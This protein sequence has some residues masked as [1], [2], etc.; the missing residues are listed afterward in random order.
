VVSIFEPPPPR[1]RFSGM[2]IY[3]RGRCQKWA[4]VASPQG[5]D[6]SPTYL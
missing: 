1:L 4:R 2:T 6:T 5:S 3:V